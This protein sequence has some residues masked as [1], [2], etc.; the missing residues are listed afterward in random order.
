MVEATR[1][2]APETGRRAP[3]RVLAVLGAAAMSFSVLQSAG[4]LL[5][6]Q[7]VT[8]FAA[9]LLA[10]RLSATIG[11]ARA[12]RAGVVLSG[13]SFALLATARTQVWQVLLATIMIGGAVGLT[14]SAM[15]NVIVQAVP[16]DQTGIATG[17]NAN[18]RT[19]GGA[20]GGQVTA[21]IVT[22]GPKILGYPQSGRFTVRLVILVAVSVAAAVI[23]ASVPGSLIPGKAGPCSPP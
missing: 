23:A 2:A 14:I 13:A 16:A 10:G 12:V 8:M 19:I 21:S 3:G 17:M 9:G 15:P 1:Q 11:S 5:L 20:L 6:P 7:T 4:L 22:S 18:V